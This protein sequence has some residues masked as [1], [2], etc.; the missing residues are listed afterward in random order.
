[1]VCVVVTVIVSYM[2]RP[3]PVAELDGLVYGATKIPEE[4]DDHWYQKPI[5][6]AGVI[7]VIFVGLNIIF[8]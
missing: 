6:W 3:R 4:H 1:L 7:A 5:V 2:T 8:W